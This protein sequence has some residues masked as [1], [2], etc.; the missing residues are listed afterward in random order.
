MNAQVNDTMLL[1]K[2]CNM[3]V[4]Y[5]SNNRDSAIICSKIAIGLAEKLNQKFYKASALCDLGYNYILNVDY[6]NALANLLIAKKMA[7]D[8]NIGKN[9]I[10]TTYLEYY[11]TPGDPEKN[12]NHL[13]VYIKNNLAISYG[14]MG[15]HSKQL[16]ELKEN[17]AVVNSMNSLSQKYIVTNNIGVAF[18]GMDKL[19]SALYYELKANELEIKLGDISNL[20][21]SNYSLGEIYTGMKKYPLAKK[22]YL[23]ALQEQY[24][25]NN[26]NDFAETQ[27]SLGRLYRNMGMLDSSLYYVRESLINFRSMG[28]LASE[29]EEVFQ[30]LSLVFKDKNNIDSAY[31]YLRLAK[32]ARDS[33]SVK[34]LNTVTN[35]HN[36]N[37]EEQARITE[38]ETERIKN[39]N[40][41]QVLL[42]I[43]S[44]IVFCIIAFILYRSNNIK[45]KANI[46]LGQQKNQIENTLHKLEATQTQLIQSEKMASLGE[47][48]AGIAHEIQNP[49][50]F[51]NNFSEVSKELLEE[52]NVELE[53]GEFEEAKA[54]AV[55]LIQNLAK[56]NHHGKRADAIVKGMLQHS[57]SNNGVKEP[58]DINALCD[59]Y[60][61]LSYHGLRAKDKS[62]N[63]TLKTDFDT[64]IGKINIISQDIGRV[65]LNL[66]TN[67]FY[68][69]DEKKKS[70]IVNFE[71]T[72]S[73]STKK[74]ADKVEIRV[75]DNGNGITQKVLDKIFQPFFTTKPA[76]QGTGLGLSLSYEIITKG[77]GGE[78]KVES[79][80]GEG[81]TFIFTLPA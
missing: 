50:N 46:L 56:I 45:K 1:D 60:L 10:K 19:D 54:I 35:F 15:N 26:I 67:A 27:M 57:R 64:S 37:F 31:Y 12:R 38:M 51:V 52:M 34:E 21:K 81:S 36:M 3:A 24:K 14:G 61:R 69:V 49:L 72:V 74:F 41:N 66:L 63:A 18:L 25:S 44:L 62:F 8:I 6:S 79:R 55:D 17:L 29:L 30:T 68:V 5:G 20:G 33:L 7:E 23:Y 47:L 13:L 65:I 78:L 28:M 43:A 80:E 39:K 75:S 22:N 53:K 16:S 70:G 32:D 9:I 58:T 40:R 76:G 71:P 42:L 73:I 11:F 59:E 4:D 48:T 2:Y 77:H